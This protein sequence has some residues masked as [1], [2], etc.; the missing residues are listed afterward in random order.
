MEEKRVDGPLDDESLEFEN[1][2][3]AAE[4][5]ARTGK[6][7]RTCLRCGRALS[8]EF[9]GASCRVVCDSEGRVI[10]SLRGI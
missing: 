10:F 9:V 4:D 8:I 5:V 3:R 2:L 6:T 1:A 7:D